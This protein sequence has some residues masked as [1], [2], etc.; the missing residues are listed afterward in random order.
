MLQAP[1]ITHEA[2]TPKCCC[3]LVNM[4]VSRGLAACNKAAAVAAGFGLLH[5]G[6][7]GACLCQAAV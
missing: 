7:G 2:Y 5:A 4:Q 3:E 6:N 1:K